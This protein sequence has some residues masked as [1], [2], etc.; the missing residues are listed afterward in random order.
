MFALL[1]I[2][3]QFAACAALIVY[4][5]AALSRYGDIIADKTGL[6][7]NW[8]GLILLATVTSL[9]ELATGASAV[10][11]ANAPN[12]AVGDV[13]G[14]CVF[15]LMLLVVLDFLHREE[16]FYRRASQGHILSAAFGIVLIGLAGASILFAQHSA[17]ISFRHI[18]IYVPIFIILYFAAGRAIFFYQRDHI[19]E[20]VEESAS[21]YPDTTLMQA[22][23]R[24]GLSATIVVAAGIWLPF[25]GTELA[26]AMHW[27]KSFVGTMFIAGA[28]SLPEL[29]VTVAALRLRALDMAIASLLGSNLF[30][31]VILAIDDL[32]YKQGPLLA[33]VSDMHAM[34][35]MSAVIM[36]GMIII[37]LLYRPQHR[38]MRAVGWVSIGL[39]LV[40][41][42][43]SYVMYLYGE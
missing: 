26:D 33:H 2:W 42:L 40:Y 5:G 7:G 15:N 23:A 32:L 24:Y 16:S 20:D 11:V 28:T 41:L 36:N 25:I 9:P 34:T 19:T 31:I 37:G 18:G 30:D 1:L 6:S 21:R 35:A 22:L 43:N 17:L 38:V 27:Q 39:A 8:V 12:I 10:T 29:S 4:A 3:I 13:L 14:S